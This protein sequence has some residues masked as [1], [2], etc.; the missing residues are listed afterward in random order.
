MSTSWTLEESNILFQGENLVAFLFTARLKC[1]ELQ[2]SWFVCKTVHT[3]R[4]EVLNILYIEIYRLDKFY[5]LKHEIR[6]WTYFLSSCF[7]C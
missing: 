6:R 4:I 2:C 3:E 5:E 1:A 7:I